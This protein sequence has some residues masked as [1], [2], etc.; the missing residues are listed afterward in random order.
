MFYHEEL[1]GMVPGRGLYE[2]QTEY[3]LAADYDAL[4]SAL[5]AEAKRLD[6][7]EAKHTLHRSV[8]I[9]YVVDGYTVQEVHE[10]YLGLYEPVHGETL[11]AAIDAAMEKLNGR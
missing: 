5:T 11:R 8:E 7:L 10:N 6:W 3:V 4:R 1:S 9:V 2:G